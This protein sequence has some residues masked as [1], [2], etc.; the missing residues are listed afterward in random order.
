MY[1]KKNNN[2]YFVGDWG[3]GH[4]SL[5][6]DKVGE[7]LRCV[8]NNKSIAPANELSSVINSLNLLDRNGLVNLFGAEME[9]ICEKESIW[10][11]IIGSLNAFFKKN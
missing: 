4:A 8:I 6:A 2:Y 7:L 11:R 10:K 1:Q 5:P 3:Q 9:S